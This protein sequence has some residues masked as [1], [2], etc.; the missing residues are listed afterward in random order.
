MAGPASQAAADAQAIAESL[1]AKKYSTIGG[2]V[3]SPQITLAAAAVTT[4]DWTGGAFD[5]HV[6]DP[7]DGTVWAARYTANTE[8][9]AVFLGRS[10]PLKAPY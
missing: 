3:E 1:A 6:Y 8:R 10:D 2:V 7:A 9:N 5:D 4:D